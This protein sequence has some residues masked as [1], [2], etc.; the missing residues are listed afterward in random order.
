MFN[1][2]AELL[3]K[4]F[5][6]D[7]IYHAEQMPDGT[8]RKSYGTVSIG[9]LKSLLIN[10]GSVAVYQKNNDMSVKWICFDFDILKKNLNSVN[11][12][13]ARVELKRAVEYFCRGLTEIEVPYLLEFSGNRGFHIWIT[14]DEVINYRNAYELQQ[15]ILEKI[16]FN[17]D[18]NLIAVDLF[19]SSGVPTDGVGLGVKIPLSKHK[20]TGKYSIILGS[21]N[22]FNFDLNVQVLT[23]EIVNRQVSILKAHVGTTKNKIENSFGVFFNT[24]YEDNSRINRIREICI[25]R[26]YSLEEIFRHWGNEEPLKSL[27]YNITSAKSLNN[28]QRKLLVGLLAN[29]RCA[30]DSSY[31]L[32]LLHTIFKSMPNY[33]VEKTEAAIK[34]LSSFY[35]PTQEQIEVTFGGRFSGKLS[36][37]DVLNACLPGVLRVEDGVFEFSLKDIDVVR[38][39]ELNYLFINDEV[40]SKLVINSLSEVNNGRLLQEVNTLLNHPSS[41]EF[42]KHE[43][44]EP[45]KVRSLF[46]LK[47]TE[48]VL[49]SLILKQLVYF[50]D[51][52]TSYNSHGYVVNRGFKDGHIFKPWLY[53]W[54]KFISNISSVLEDSE[55]QSFYVVKTD[56]KSFYDSIPHDNLKRLLLGGVNSKVDVNLNKLTG[57]IKEKYNLLI[58]RVFSLTETVLGVKVGL[59]QGPAYARYFAELY[60][61]NLDVSF[62][63]KLNSGVLKFYHRYV[64]DIFFVASTEE[65][66]NLLLEDLNLR[67]ISIGLEV[68][69]EKTLINKIANFGD[70]FNEYRSQS[71]YAV[72]KVS[73]NYS[74]ATDNQKDMAISEFIKLIESE[75]GVN[76]MAFVFSHLNG[77]YHV[78]SLKRNKVVPMINSRI[79][80][81]SMFKHIFGFILDN[82][83]N[84]DLFDQID[85]LDV[86][87]SEVLTAA[88]ISAYETRLISVDKL[89]FLFEKILGKISKSEL[90]EEHLAYIALN[91]G[92]KVAL[93]MVRPEY[94]IQVLQSLTVAESLLVSSELISYLNT[95]L[96][97]IKPLAQFIEVIYPLCVCDSILSTDLNSLASVFFAKLSNDHVVGVLDIRENTEMFTYSVSEKFYY[98]LSLFT[99]SN[100]NNSI[101]LVK[102]M[103]KY[104]AFLFNNHNDEIP[105]FINANWFTKIGAIQFEESKVQWVVSSIVDGN[106]F[107][108]LDDKRKVFERFHNYLLVFV[109]FKVVSGSDF[110]VDIELNKLRGMAIFYDWLID[111]KDVSFFPV[112]SKLWFEKNIIEN[113]MIAIKKGDEVLFRKPTADF[114]ESSKPT[115]EHKGYSEVVV[116]Y[117]AADNKALSDVID[118]LTLKERIRLILDVVSNNKDDRYPNI[119]C[120]DP[121]YDLKVKSA[122]NVEFNNLRAIVF[123]DRDSTV[124]AFDNNQKNFIECFVRY[125][126]SNKAS[127]DLRIISQKYLKNLDDSIDLLSFLSAVDQQLSEVSDIEDTLVYD[128]SIAAALYSL[129]DDIE[130]IRKIDRFLAQYHKFNHEDVDRHIYCVLDGEVLN[131]ATPFYFLASLEKSLEQIPTKYITTLSLYLHKD[132]QSIRGTLDKLLAS[133]DFVD[134]DAPLIKIKSHR[135]LHTRRMVN[136]DGVDYDFDKIYLINIVSENLTVFD[137]RYSVL[138]DGA[139]H[140]YSRVAGGKIYVLSM[141]GSLSKI[142]RSIEARSESGA[143]IIN[144]P[145][146]DNEGIRSLNRLNEAVEKIALQRDIGIA[147]ARLLLINWLSYLPRKSRQPLVTLLA[148]HEVMSNEDI[149]S[150]VSRARALLDNPNSNPFL[151][152]RLGDFNGTH[153]IIYSK[154]GDFG[155]K[156]EAWTPLNI[157][158]GATM[159]T[160]VTDIVVSGKQLISALKYYL[161][162]DI[163]SSVN[164]KYFEL[165]AQ[166]RLLV[167]QR[168]K[169]IKRLEICVVLYTSRARDYIKNELATIYGNDF[170]V[171]F[172]CGRNIGDNAF[173]GTTEKIG[174]AEKDIIIKMVTDKDLMSSLASRLKYFT[175]EIKKYASNSQEFFDDFNLVGRYKSL[176][177][178]SFKFLCSGLVHD[179]EIQPFSKVFENNERL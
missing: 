52:N 83:M 48:R 14:F 36:T 145:Q 72:D 99:I 13:C 47:T 32:D 23:D 85:V 27:V 169:A 163:T 88:F 155:R 43:R 21:I 131:D 167:K 120:S 104:C 22:E 87:Q 149:G 10:S 121:L 80:R 91:Y 29:V 147:D 71:K 37:I 125:S 24:Y 75:N 68:N 34:A 3:N 160:I 137:T 178:K 20:K 103:W 31:G 2:L 157:K 164:D 161:C 106:I 8:Y 40:Q 166:D 142:Y 64:D 55:Y 136:F 165:S 61:D 44:N 17:Y 56:I 82:E 132:I 117:N 7:Q 139:D 5:S 129:L 79:G 111:R 175:K 69:L 81:G 174:S 60:L 173:F 128:V 51:V 162:E 78:D 63:E 114:C 90:V 94:Y 122:F 25:D 4:Y 102:A 50:L 1:E 76:D 58:D 133:C 97:D 73:K 74:D 66:A 101:D 41:A 11:E 144:C 151:I 49:T 67:L 70:D 152:K 77:V 134:G 127:D 59:P 146:I 54:I 135:V 158:Q 6:T 30:N 9:L 168:L 140:I 107:R 15:A 150:F 130:P 126:S 113:N 57:D 153:R 96:N 35:F 28:N 92:A 176:P 112:T 156:V 124:Q 84:W 45:A 159:A 116:K 19:P 16:D 118:G 62:E 53:Q 172:V 110:N 177:K 33:S 98:L 89:N 179:N 12:Q 100:K 18:K 93:E 86:I 143:T 26:K 39:A 154:G 95:P 141:P 109:A 105:K 119:F 65:D 148:A 38:V 42:Y 46:T 108:G 170:S 115:N 171:D 138:L 123:L